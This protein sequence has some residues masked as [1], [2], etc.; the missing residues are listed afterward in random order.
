MLDKVKVKVKPGYEGKGFM[1]TGEAVGLV[2]NRKEFDKLK[3]GEPV[4]LPY[5]IADRLIGTMYFVEIK[6][7]IKKDEVKNKG[8]E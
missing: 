7:T 4:F 1:W 2:G 6:T 8:D 3:S 5:Q